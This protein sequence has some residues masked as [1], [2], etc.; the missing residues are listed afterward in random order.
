MTAWRPGLLAG[1]AWSS[2]RAQPGRSL[3]AVLA[4]A[5]GIALGLAIHLINHSA[6]A[7]FSRAV[8]SLAGQADLS[9][10]GPLP[11]DLYPDLARDPDVMAASPAI[12]LRVNIAGRREALAVLGLDPFRAAVLTPGLLARPATEGEGGGAPQGLGLLA[13]E[14]I[15]LSPAARE[16]LGVGVGD[17]LAVQ[18]GTAT[19]S[20]RVAGGL[21]AV[22]AGRRLGVMDIAGAQWRLDRLGELTRIDLKLRPGADAGAFRA[23]WS[24]RLPA[25]ARFETAASSDQRSANISRAY[26][27]NLSVLALVALFTGAF[28]VFS[29]QVLSLLRRRSQLAL[30][31]V[32]GLTRGELATLVLLEGGVLGLA[33][34]LAGV[35]GGVAVAGAALDLLGGDLGGGYFNGIRPALSLPPD[36]LAGFLL[37]GA[38]ASLAGCLAPAWSA[39]RARPA[40]ALKA[41]DEETAMARIRKPW[42]GL[43]L[44]VAAGA[45]LT[46]GPVDELPLPGYGAVACLLV[47]GLALMPWLT[48]R[49]LGLVPKAWLRRPVA[50]LALTQLREA[51]GYAGIGL[52]GIL[53]SF[54]LMAAMAIMVASFRVSL[55]D[56]LDHV[57]P[58]QIYLRVG[59][60]G[61]TGFLSPEAQ[62]AIV[63]TPG[64]ARADFLRSRALSL[65]PRRPDVLLLARAISR[66]SPAAR[67]PL[68]GNPVRVSAD[69]VPVWVSEAVVDLYGVKPGDAWHLPL[70]GRA[71]QVEVAG[72][73]RDYARQH[74]AVAIAMEDYRRLTGDH[75]VNDVALWLAEGAEAGRVQAAIRERLDGGA[76]LSFVEAGELR[77]I[78][79]D[80]FDRSFA[81][82]YLLEVVA[83]GV[84]LA[85]IGVSFGGQALARLREFGML[86][87][88][89]FRRR[90]LDALLALEG[91][92]LAAVG[93]AAG[94]VLGWLI[95]QV[96]I[97]VVNPQSFHWT[98]D[99]TIPWGL[100]AAVSAALVA[101]ASLT[102]LLA[103]RRALSVGAVRAVKEDW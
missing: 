76:G 30:L 31:R 92:L 37:L 103:G 81:V 11:E 89:G 71:V 19:V 66:E 44:F 18:V 36:V 6:V 34:S 22:G 90:D 61:E 32:L 29:T 69:A 35:A 94:L 28:L 41:G 46:V 50:G 67:L 16:W 9:V 64:V 85:G 58:A 40:A 13:P 25:G 80:I 75:R 74:G 86:R 2:I 52:A 77:R 39:A 62:A 42:A 83:V 82:T 20:L 54:S 93:V 5:V 21:P 102:S 38:A 17:A 49:L 23:R 27:V 60:G 78:S 15:F 79:L 91:A 48:A 63:A 14:A 68:V 65:D 3:V 87:H 70:A 95:S 43:A 59:S 1:L 88:L 12:E 101:L 51:P 47:G 10:Q 84:G 72:V 45:L 56:W 96:L 97:R 99:T 98:M 8:A 53:A 55:S 26:R 24:G 7:E 57:L 73:W 100:L 33:G 4:I